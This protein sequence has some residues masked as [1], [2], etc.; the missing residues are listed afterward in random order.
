MQNVEAEKAEREYK[1]P[2]KTV[3]HQELYEGI[4]VQTKQIHTDEFNERVEAYEKAIEN[5]S[6]EDDEAED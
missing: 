1:N 4:N 5:E 3:N 2:F 6:K